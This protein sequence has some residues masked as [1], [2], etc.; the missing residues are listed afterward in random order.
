MYNVPATINQSGTVTGFTTAT[1]GTSQATQNIPNGKLFVVASKGGTQPSAVDVHSA[2]R[3]FSIL[4]TVPQNIQAL[5]GL[6][7][8]GVL[9][10]VPVNTYSIGVKKGATPLAGQ[11]AAVITHKLSSSIPAGVD[12]ADPD[13]LAASYLLMASLCVQMAQEVINTQKTGVG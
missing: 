11:P 6:N 12:L 13:N 2:S 8:A 4:C 10:Y 5:P 3:P 1:W 9:P 7:N